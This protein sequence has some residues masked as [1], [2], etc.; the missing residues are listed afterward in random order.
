M[1][2]KI[3][4]DELT[5]EIDDDVD[6]EFDEATIKVEILS[7]KESADQSVFELPE[8]YEVVGN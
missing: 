2:M 8:D 3:Y 4:A 7:Y 1:E 5:D 6:F